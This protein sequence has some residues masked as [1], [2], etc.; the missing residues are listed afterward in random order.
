MAE[1]S[2]SGY[3]EPKCMDDESRIELKDSPTEPPWRMFCQSRMPEPIATNKSSL[4]VK[5]NLTKSDSKS[6][7][8]AEYETL[9][10][11]KR[12]YMKCY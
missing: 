2:I 8:V 5:L 1:R 11:E 12:E 7:F 10:F 4:F 9:Q 3:P 6:W